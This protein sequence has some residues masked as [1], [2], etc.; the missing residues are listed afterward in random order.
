VP[1]NYLN[2]LTIQ[3]WRSGQ[4]FEHCV[5]ESLILRELG[6]NLEY[7]CSYSELY[8][9]LKGT[10][11]EDVIPIPTTKRRLFPRFTTKINL[12]LDIQKIKSFFQQNSMKNIIEVPVN[13][14]SIMLEN[15][16]SGVIY[17]SDKSN[18]ADIYKFEGEKYIGFQ[19]KCGTSR[20]FGYEDF[21]TEINKAILHQDSPKKWQFVLVFAIQK[22][23]SQF[24]GSKEVAFRRNIISDGKAI[25]VLFS[26]GYTIKKWTLPDNVNVVVLYEE[27]LRLLLGNPIY[28][29]LE[30]GVNLD[31]VT[32]SLSP[33]S[34]LQPEKPPV[35]NTNLTIG[36]TIRVIEILESD[37]EDPIP[38]NEEDSD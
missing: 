28:N 21:K 8:P 3:D 33:P 26:P 29:Y 1:I 19:T 38:M 31:T 4:P 30:E 35:H 2:N 12:T 24:S 14:K 7:K 10:Y 5:V 9:F 32:S 13:A 37:D 17:T 6:S 11:L 25:A 36:T 23:S 18:A 20:A 22:L 16:Q 34:F 15:I 27:G